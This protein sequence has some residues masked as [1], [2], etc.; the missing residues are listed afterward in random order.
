MNTVSFISPLSSFKRLKAVTVGAQKLT[1]VGFFLKHLNRLIH[2]AYAKTKVFGLWVNVIKIKE[3]RV[4]NGTP[5]AL[6]SSTINQ[7]FSNLSHFLS[8]RHCGSARVL[9][10]FSLVP[11]L[12]F[13]Q[14]LGSVFSVKCRKVSLSPSVYLLANVLVL[15]WVISHFGF[16]RD[17]DFSLI[18][19]KLD[20]F[21]TWISNLGV[22][23]N[24][25][26]GSLPPDESLTAHNL[27]THLFP[28]I[29]C[30]ILAWSG[31]L[32][33]GLISH[34]LVTAQ[35]RGRDGTGVAFREASKANK[36][37]MQS[38][39]F[40]QSYSAKTFVALHQDELRRARVSPV[41]IAHT[42]RA[43]LGMSL[44]AQNAHPFLSGKTF[45]IHNGLIRNWRSIDPSVTTDSMVLGP[46]LDAWA[47]APTIGLDVSKF[48]GMMGVA[49]LR[50]DN[51][52]CF[53][54]NQDLT[55][56]EIVWTTSS[57]A[58]KQVCVVASTLPIIER[59]LSHT[60][61]SAEIRE[62]ELD[63][64]HVYAVTPG[65]PIPVAGLTVNQDCYE[66]DSVA[67]LTRLTVAEDADDLIPDSEKEEN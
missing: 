11:E 5:H 27:N 50:G 47:K 17:V 13:R 22:V 66:E 45:F 14:E 1:L 25:G 46:T 23:G 2:D 60:N 42:R 21:W 20:S 3:Q 44:T 63:E 48:V 15:I 35:C 33:V 26:F 7:L 67:A 41:G 61:V 65:G 8:V 53:K 39:S 64:G 31:E 12:G 30:A 4:V 9:L 32:P 51:A 37:K 54:V 49:W 29:G 24:P 40:R 36:D 10:D 55:A 16:P 38:V 43:S 59:A 28:V 6:S 52:Y 18:G 62:I 19:Q 58:K 57:G 56:A 34:L